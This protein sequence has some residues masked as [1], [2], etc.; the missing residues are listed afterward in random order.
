ML[1]SFLQLASGHL[2]GKVNQ[3]INRHPEPIF[4]Q[5]VNESQEQ[6]STVLQSTLDEAKSDD[7]LTGNDF[8]EKVDL[9]T[10]DYAKKIKPRLYI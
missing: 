3:G 5:E 6:K 2:R 7:S 10:S 8:L 4:S 1:I 9:V